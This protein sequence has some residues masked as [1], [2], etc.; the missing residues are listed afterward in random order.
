MAKL[1]NSVDVLIIGAGISG[2][3]A[4]FH[5]Q[6]DCPQ[7]SYTLIEAR[8]DLGGTW[9]LFKYPGI[10]SDSD[11][12]TFGYEFK[13]WTHKKTI[14]DGDDIKAYIKDTATEN[15]IYEKIRFQT[16]VMD[17]DWSSEKQMW[18]V[19]L[20]HE[21]TGEESTVEARWIF[22]ASGY[23]RYDQGFAPSFPNQEAFEGPII[24]P[25]AW[26]EDLDY[27]N[28]NV[29]V[30]GS[31]ATAITLV[32]AMADKTKHITML[33]RT[34]TYVL[35]VPAEDP[36]AKKLREYFKEETAFKYARKFHIGKQRYIFKFCQTFPKQARK[37]IRYL[38]KK[39]LPDDYPVDVHF[40]PPYNPWDQ[41]LCAV[42]G[43]DLFKVISNGSASMVTDQIESFNAKGIKLKSG[44]QLDAD[45]II[46]ATGLNLLPLGG[47]RPK[48]DGKQVSLPEHVAYKG[49]LLSDIPNFAMAV[50]YTSSSWTLKVGLVCEYFTR[51]L[52]YMSENNYTTCTPKADPN[53]KKV[54]LLN[55]GAGYIQRSID[56]L[57]KQGD[58]YPWSMSWNYVDD[59]KIFRKGKIDDPALSFSRQ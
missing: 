16:R 10:R 44:K 55:F 36:I 23:Y 35:P 25:Q 58:K 3:G 6:R 22:N 30:I 42:P 17:L 1:S 28:K 7:L 8:D 27:T 26:P 59:T 38:N 15:G 18:Q 21:K 4:G 39:M 56:A 47:I 29:V 53:M 43:G 48:I 11:L 13:P 9:D 31:G 49:V 14:A 12:F 34:P 41:R 2:I 40:N 32:P 52:N 33:Q 20:R 45:I 54:P 46:T 19:S 5:L 57:P 24:H 51:L 50:G 37:L